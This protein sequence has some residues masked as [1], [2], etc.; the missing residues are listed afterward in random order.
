MAHRIPSGSKRGG[1]TI[2]EMI[3]VM[4]IISIIVSIAIPIYQ[5]SLIRAR[6][7]VLKN[8]LYTMRTVIDEYTYDKQKAPQDL[9]D[10]VDA[11]YLR[12]IPL[13]PMTGRSDTWRV[14]ME[15]ATAS[16]NQTEPGIYNVRSG[17]DQKSLE[18]TPY[19]EW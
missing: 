13:D 2:V 10:L 5:K 6:E 18:G 7:S 8:N 15:D 12:T 17:S 16:V 9:R 19:S 4:T 3:I 1:F 14:E 11:G